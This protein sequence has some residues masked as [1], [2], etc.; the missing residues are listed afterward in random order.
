MP[1]YYGTL[2]ICESEE[3]N[4]TEIT[5]ALINSEYGTSIEITDLEVIIDSAI[6]TV[7]HD[8]GTSIGYMT[9]GAGAKTITVTGS[10]AAA[11][12]PLVAMKLISRT[13]Q[14]ASSSTINIGPLGKSQSASSSVNDINAELYK[15][16][17][18][19]LRGR[20]FERV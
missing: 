17:I 14:G 5:G 13:I 11:I 1:R 9:G 8:A 19:V 3:A 15:R 12:K 4:L 20:S 18:D 7:N 2:F 16:A 10:Q 6:D